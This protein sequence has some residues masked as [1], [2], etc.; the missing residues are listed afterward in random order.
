MLET[1]TIIHEDNSEIT[2]IDETA[3]GVECAQHYFVTK[4]GAVIKVD[5]A[6][7]R[8]NGMTVQG[9]WQIAN[10]EKDESDRL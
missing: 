4:N 8:T 2:G 10:G 1:H 5:D 7:K 9:G 3:T 6:S